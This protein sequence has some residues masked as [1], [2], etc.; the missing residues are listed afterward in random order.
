[1]PLLAERICDS[2]TDANKK[3]E[4]DQKPRP[5]HTAVRID[6][7]VG[8][9][10][11]ASWRLHAAVAKHGAAK[12]ETDAVL[13][14]C[15]FGTAV[16]AVKT[17]IVKVLAFVRVLCVTDFVSAMFMAPHPYI[18]RCRPCC[19]CCV[20]QGVNAIRCVPTKPSA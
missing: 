8:K 11:R 12:G 19:L 9:I 17:S 1:M 3:Y 20:C 13:A 16:G 18:N 4:D 7:G 2:S 5:V 15:R 6:V 14:T 10:V